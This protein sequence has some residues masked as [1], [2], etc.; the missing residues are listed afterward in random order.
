MVIIIICTSLSCNTLL[1]VSFT[2]IENDIRGQCL[3]RQSSKS[4]DF[5]LE[6]RAYKSLKWNCFVDER[7]GKNPNRICGNATD[8][9]P[10]IYNAKEQDPHGYAFNP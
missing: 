3:T 4:Q 10:K 1:S 6:G 2:K 7:T 9:P 8:P 5:Y